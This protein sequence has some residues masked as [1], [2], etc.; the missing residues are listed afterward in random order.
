MSLFI[1]L[2]IGMAMGAATGFWFRRNADYILIDV[3]A[4]IGGSILGLALYFFAANATIESL[5]S[6][7][8][9]VAEV[10]GAAILLIA[11]QLVITIPK[12][13][14]KILKGTEEE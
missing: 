7:R 8:A 1:A 11:Y 4:G 5:V 3:L 6:W 2:L 9:V 14:K 10:L 12:E 13:K